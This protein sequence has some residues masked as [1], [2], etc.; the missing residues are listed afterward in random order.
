MPYLASTENDPKHW[1]CIV[2]GCNNRPIACCKSRHGHHAY[3]ADHNFARHAMDRAYTT[4]AGYLAPIATPS[5]SRPD[6]GP[7]PPVRPI[8][9]S[10]PQPPA[11]GGA[12]VDQFTRPQPARVAVPDLEF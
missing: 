1:L 2:H 6:I 4:P 8:G 7:M 3:C 9:P 5:S 12:S 10:S 11:P